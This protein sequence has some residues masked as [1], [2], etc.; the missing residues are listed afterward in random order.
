MS[1]RQPPNLTLDCI[2]FGLQ[3]VG[4]ISNYSIN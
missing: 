4:G 3:R 1:A 2:I